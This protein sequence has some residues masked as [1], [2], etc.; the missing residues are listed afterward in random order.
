MATDIVKKA[1]ETLFTII[2][3]PIIMGV[4]YAIDTGNTSGWTVSAILALS[5]IEFVII[6]GVARKLYKEWSD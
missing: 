4:F 6:L 3:L 2:I 5:V 1:L